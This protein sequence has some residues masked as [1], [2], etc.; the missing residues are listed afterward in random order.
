MS[1]KRKPPDQTERPCREARFTPAP[2]TLRSGRKDRAIV[3][4]A[5]W[6]WS[7]SRR[8]RKLVRMPSCSPCSVASGSAS[9]ATRAPPSARHQSGRRPLAVPAALQPGPEPDR[10]VFAKLK[11]LLRKAD[12]RSVVAVWKRIGSC[13]MCSTSASAPG[14]SSFFLS[15]SRNMWPNSR[16]VPVPGIVDVEP[17]RFRSERTAAHWR[18]ARQVG[19]GWLSCPTS[20]HTV[21]RLFTSMQSV[22]GARICVSEH[23]C[24]GALRAPI[25]EAV[26]LE[27]SHG[28]GALP[29]GKAEPRGPV[30][31]ISY[32]LRPGG[33]GEC[34]MVET[35]EAGGYG[36]GSRV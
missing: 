16:R 15:Q 31:H 12:E 32:S 23:V 5:A 36:R 17:G 9:R 30:H 22:P 1:G 13:S 2:C 34:E 27:T 19:R 8:G 26:R 4:F 20:I 7:R 25:N 6:R 29:S 10:M 33:N 18:P 24:D 3:R 28:S 14:G 21:G 11:T 35:G